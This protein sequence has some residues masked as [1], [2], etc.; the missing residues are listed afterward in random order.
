[1]SVLLGIGLMLLYEVIK[2]G[3]EVVAVMRP[4]GILGMILH[5]E[6]R[7]FFMPE[8]FERFVIQI[9]MGHFHFVLGQR[10]DRHHKIVVLGSDLDLPGLKVHDRLVIAV[11][12][13]LEFCGLPAER[14]PD[15]LVPEADPEHRDLA[16][17]LADRSDQVFHRGDRKS[18]V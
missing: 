16:D 6:D 1:M 18:V 13:E 2:T 14:L 11:V 15:H 9:N 7:M 3:E 10:I 4:R 8:P 17:E 12:P 5:A